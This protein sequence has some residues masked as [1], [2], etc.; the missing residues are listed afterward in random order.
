MQMQKFG[1]P[2]KWDTVASHMDLVACPTF[3]L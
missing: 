1:V 2:P 3:D